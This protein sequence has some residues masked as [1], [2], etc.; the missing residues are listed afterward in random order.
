MKL[1]GAYYQTGNFVDFVVCESKNAFD[2]WLEEQT[3]K[4]PS[5]KILK[6]IEK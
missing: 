6:Q 4:Y 5:F 1:I 2:E 3:K